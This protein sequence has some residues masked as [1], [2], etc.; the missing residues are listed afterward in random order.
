MVMDGSNERCVGG[1]MVQRA[2]DG[3]REHEKKNEKINKITTNEEGE[4]GA[5]ARRETKGK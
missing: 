1:A 5:T 2:I 4:Y 3:C